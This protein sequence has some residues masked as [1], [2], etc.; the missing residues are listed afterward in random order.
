MND[1]YKTFKSIC[2]SVS[3][4]VFT[5]KTYNRVV[6]LQRPE[7]ATTASENTEAAIRLI[8]SSQLENFKIPE[9]F[10]GKTGY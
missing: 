7:E 10:D 3:Q 9:F 6:S 1:L 8:K 2:D 4:D 5:S